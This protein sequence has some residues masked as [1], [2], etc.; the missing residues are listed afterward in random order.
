MRLID[1]D[2]LMELARKHVNRTVDCNDIAR[3]PTIDA[4]P[5]VH[6][7]WINGD[8]GYLICPICSCEHH[9]R[10]AY[11]FDTENDYCPRCGAKMDG[12]AG[13]V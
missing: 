5:V 8:Y 6:A 12:G 11:R 4:V 1:A 7:E 3:F 9:R 13:N 2:A 10:D